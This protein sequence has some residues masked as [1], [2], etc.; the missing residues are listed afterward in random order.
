M[1]RFGSGT[2]EEN[3]QITSDLKSLYGSACQIFAALP[4]G[5]GE[6]PLFLLVILDDFRPLMT[7]RALSRLDYFKRVR[8][9]RQ[10]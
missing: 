7:M 4:P 1:R 8:C 9:V 10:G 5:T 2:R 6:H 3:Y